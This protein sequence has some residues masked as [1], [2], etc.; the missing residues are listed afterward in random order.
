MNPIHGW[1]S[2]ELLLLFCALCLF[3]LPRHVMN[4][5][6]DNS[7]MITNNTQRNGVENAS[8]K[9]VLRLLL[10]SVLQQNPGLSNQILQNPELLANLR[11][12]LAGLSNQPQMQPQQEQRQQRGRLLA[13]SR[14]LSLN[15]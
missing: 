4:A 14:I 5:P 15:K 12:K 6:Q 2:K 7:S 8:L 1:T 3:T 11:N 13:A 9:P 10:A